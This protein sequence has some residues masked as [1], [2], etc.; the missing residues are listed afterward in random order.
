MILVKV[1]GITR[2]EDAFLAAELGAAALGFIFWPRSPRFVEPAEAQRIVAMLPP[3]ITPVG[4]FVDQPVEHVRRVAQQVKLGA[5]QLH[6]AET[7]QYW[8][9]L[10]YRVI[11]A[12]AVGDGRAL[13]E[14]A[15]LPPAM[16]LLLD[17]HDPVQKGGT[18]R[19]IDW[20]IAARIAAERRV[21]LSGGLRPENVAAAIAAVR[22]YGVDVSSGV[23]ER[24]GVKDPARLRDFFA[25]VRG[26]PAR[27]SRS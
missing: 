8:K 19:P 25:A 27:G 2:P 6:G 10:K 4:V 22:P 5:L 3:M 26:A 1:C 13:D 16:T 15:A 24:P 9:R 11:K 14:V 18:G 20:S 12:V 23:E 17:A 21:I 7:R